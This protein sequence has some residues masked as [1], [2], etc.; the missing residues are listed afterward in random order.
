[1]PRFI[2]R[3]ERTETI[4]EVFSFDASS[5]AAARSHIQTYH[6]HY[7]A[8]SLARQFN[9]ISDEYNSSFIIVDIEEDDK[10][11]RL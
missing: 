10:E 9:R 11:S 8:E 1:M 5:P 2:V 7:G 4:R 3:T 6:D